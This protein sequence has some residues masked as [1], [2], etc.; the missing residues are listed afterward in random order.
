V[1]TCISEGGL[2]KYRYTTL[3]MVVVSTIILR[4]DLLGTGT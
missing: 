2:I 4:V 3:R 1:S